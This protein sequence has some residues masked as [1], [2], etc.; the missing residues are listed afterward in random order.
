MGVL[1][2]Y[3]Y[4]YIYTYV[5]ARTHTHPHDAMCDVTRGPCTVRNVVSAWSRWTGMSHISKPGPKRSLP[6]QREGLSPPSPPPPSPPIPP[7]PPSLVGGTYLYYGDSAMRP[8]GCGSNTWSPNEPLVQWNQR[9][10]PAVC[11]G[12]FFEA[13]SYYLQDCSK[14]NDGQTRLQFGVEH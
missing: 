6:K 1:Y 2:N 14:P 8:C 12:S 4:I 3:I 10:K 7:L 11:P 9:L 5:R 13:H